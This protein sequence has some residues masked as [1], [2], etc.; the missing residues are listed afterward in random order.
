MA[1]TIV[2][3][4]A[5]G[6]LGQRIIKALHG[7][8]AD[9]VALARAGTADDKVKA[10]EALGAKVAA[11]EM[12]SAAEIAGACAG[13]ACVVSAVQGLHD[14]I[15]EAQSILLEGT[16]AAGVPRFIPSD[17]SVDFTR[18]PEGENRNFDLRREFHRRLDAAPIAATSIFNGAFAEI[19]SYNLPLLDFEKKAVG[20]WEN[21]EWHVDFTTM[22]D[23]AAYTAAAAL[24]PTTPRALRIASFQVSPSQLVTFTEEVLKT[25]FTLVRLGS[26]DDLRAHNKSER[27]AHPEG[28]NDLY[29]AW[30]Q[31]Q[32]LQ[33]M[34]S[35]HHEALDNSRYPDVTWTKIQDVLGK[36][37]EN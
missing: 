12:S 8:G 20:Y 34:F 32:Y 21:P 26:L 30:Q 31:S 35:V 4:G 18:Q 14:V 11:I 19:L 15:V 28:E 23:T 29:A 37:S 1:A 7:R 9:V 5:T 25:P 17:F 16:L 27:A 6:N 10:L 33:S 24:D 3:A 36:R 13:A 2:V 22:D